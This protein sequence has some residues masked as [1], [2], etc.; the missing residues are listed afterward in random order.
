[1]TSPL[2]TFGPAA[3]LCAL[4]FHPIVVAQAK[5]RQPRQTIFQFR[6]DRD[7]NRGTDRM[8]A[9]P[10]EKLGMLHLFPV[11]FPARVIL[12]TMLCNAN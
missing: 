3:L 7:R 9:N 2:T 10:L 11:F 6:V 12:A 5:N 8:F 1:M 4:H